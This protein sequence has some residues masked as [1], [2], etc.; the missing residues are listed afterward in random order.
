[1]YAPNVGPQLSDDQFLQW[2]TSSQVSQPFDNS[3]VYGINANNYPVN[4]TQSSTQLARRPVNQAVSRSRLDSTGP[5][6]WTEPTSGPD[7]TGDGA[8]AD[9]IQDLE[10]RAQIAKM[11]ALAKRK[12]I[13]PFVQKLN[14]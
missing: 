11:E 9:S 8:W 4:N 10:A 1:M 7:P 12:Q 2:G 5:P 3:S 13:P 14:R 6:P